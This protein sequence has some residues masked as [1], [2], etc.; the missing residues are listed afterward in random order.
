MVLAST[1]RFS[2][3]SARSNE[4]AIPPDGPDLTE[5]VS[6]AIHDGHG[7][8]QGLRSF[9]HASTEPELTEGPSHFVW[10]VGV[11]LSFGDGFSAQYES[12]ECTKS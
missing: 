12:Q 7:H 2:S 8:D 11:T 1:R 5:N 3:D 9:I 10:T 6:T 4:I